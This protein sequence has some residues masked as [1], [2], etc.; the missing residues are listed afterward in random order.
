M[1]HHAKIIDNH[2]TIAGILKYD[3]RQNEFGTKRYYITFAINLCKSNRYLVD[4]L[5]DQFYQ[6]RITP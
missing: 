3:F 1:F 4:R 2:L 5:V 6:R